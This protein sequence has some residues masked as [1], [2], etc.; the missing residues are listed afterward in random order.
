VSELLQSLR[1]RA[2]GARHLRRVAELTWAAAF[3][4]VVCVI[5]PPVAPILEYDRQAIL[6]GEIWRV[7]TGHLV[8]WSTEHAL[9]DGVTL[10]ILCLIPA[11]LLPGRDTRVPLLEVILIS[12]VVVSATVFLLNPEFELYRGLSGICVA[13]FTAV[14]VSG[15]VQSNAAGDRRSRALFLLLLAGVI[16]KTL[17]ESVTGLTLFVSDENFVVASSAHLGGVLSGF[18]VAIARGAR[19]RSSKTPAR[20]RIDRITFESR[21]GS[22]QWRADNPLSRE[23]TGTGLRIS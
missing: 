22:R 19:L 11:W 6:A 14:V 10:L 2:L 15:I 1:W 23:G 16:C 18:A 4:F 13:V 17:Y 20:D 21:R 3:L 5:L 9:Y 7:F 12:S 8:H